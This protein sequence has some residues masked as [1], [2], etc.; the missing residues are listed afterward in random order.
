MA[1]TRTR[2]VGEV[3]RTGQ[4]LDIY[5]KVRSVGF[6]D[7]LIVGKCEKQLSKIIQV[8]LYR[9]TIYYNRYD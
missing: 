3:R 8:L 4:F 9:G 7:G 2:L 6:A 5:L 1:W